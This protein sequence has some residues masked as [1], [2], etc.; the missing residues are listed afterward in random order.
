MV[1][2]KINYSVIKLSSRFI[3]IIIIIIIISSSSI[4]VRFTSGNRW[5][6]R[7]SG[8]PRWSR[9]L[10]MTSSLAVAQ[11]R[12]ADTDGV[13]ATVGK[14]LRFATERAVCCPN[15]ATAHSNRTIWNKRNIRHYQRLLKI[16]AWGFLCHTFHSS[17][18]LFLSPCTLFLSY[19]S[20]CLFSVSFCLFSSGAPP[21]I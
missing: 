16:T 11:L 4:K 20:S 21:K 2:R 3:I 14:R 7:S 18:F 17:T 19:L 13:H 5:W 9:D 15:T 6:R 10:T 1:L 12:V 8:R